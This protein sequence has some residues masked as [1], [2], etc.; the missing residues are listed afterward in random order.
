MDGNRE[1]Y[2][3]A[4]N[5]YL[6]S[7]NNMWNIV[8]R[9]FVNKNNP[10]DIDRTALRSVQE[11]LKTERKNPIWLEFP[12]SFRDVTNSLLAFIKALDNKS[13]EELRQNYSEVIKTQDSLLQRCDGYGRMT[14]HVSWQ[15]NFCAK[16]LVL[17][18][19][20]AQNVLRENETDELAFSAAVRSRIGRYGFCDNCPF[21][22]PGWLESQI[23]P[24]D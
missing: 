13:E 6:D 1:M 5:S 17:A 10:A 14:G 2:L 15:S 9:P 12:R 8:L 11:D 19:S 23:K 22:V 4:V 7:M 21:R 18:H 20:A 16:A 24:K 3:R